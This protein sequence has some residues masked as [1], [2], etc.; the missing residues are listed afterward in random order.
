MAIGAVLVLT[1]RR[2][3]LTGA[4][5]GCG[6]FCVLHARPAVVMMHSAIP[7]RQHYDLPFR[8]RNLPRIAQVV[9]FGQSF[10]KGCW[11]FELE[12]DD[13]FEPDRLRFGLSRWNDLWL[14]TT[15]VYDGEAFS[16]CD[17]D[18][19]GKSM[20]CWIDDDSVSDLRTT[21]VRLNVQPVPGPGHP[22][23][24]RRRP[25]SHLHPLTQH[26]R[27]GSVRIICRSGCAVG[28]LSRVELAFSPSGSSGSTPGHTSADGPPR[29]TLSSQRGTVSAS[30]RRCWRR[31][32]E[33]DR[34]ARPP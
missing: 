15:L 22:Y 31:C 28:V 2:F 1:S 27:A 11:T 19:M 24:T 21:T 18:T 20:E 29:S 12:A 7:P 26:C 25:P 17:V 14:L 30:V 23:P 4:V 3:A 34:T 10:E 33:D 13:D 6:A 32:G 8:S 5:G 16:S 9:V